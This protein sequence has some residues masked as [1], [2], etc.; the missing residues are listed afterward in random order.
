M[1]LPILQLRFELGILPVTKSHI[2][3]AFGWNSPI[4]YFMDRMVLNF[5]HV[6]KTGAP[7]RIVVEN[8]DGRLFG[9]DPYV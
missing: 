7:G 5:D 4:S 2:R 1:Q 8:K 3:A 9:N 6:L